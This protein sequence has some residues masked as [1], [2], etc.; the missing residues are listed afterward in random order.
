MTGQTV[1]RYEKGETE[2]P[3]PADKLLRFV[4]AMHLLN[5]REGKAVLDELN[6]ALREDADD[7]APTPV[8]F[9]TTKPGEWDQARR[10][11]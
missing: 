4:Y 6:S 9:A 1:A 8:Y 7:K 10:V 3:G 2:I 5:Q 11:S